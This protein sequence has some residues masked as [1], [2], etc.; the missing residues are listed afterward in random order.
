MLPTETEKNAIEKI[1]ATKQELEDR[2]VE[3]DRLEVLRPGVEVRASGKVD[4][5]WDASRLRCSELT[6]RQQDRLVEARGGVEYE[7]DELHATADRATL[8]VDQET[9]VLEHVDLRL[10]GE[11]GRLGGTRL[12]T[13]LGPGTQVVEIEQRDGVERA[14]GCVHIAR[15]GDVHDE[16]RA[17]LRNWAKLG[18][19]A[20][21]P[22]TGSLFAPPV[23]TS[24]LPAA[25]AAP[26]LQAI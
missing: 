14:D 20:A 19:P 11:A 2:R 4:V 22:Q 12:E 16:Q 13:L 26:P 8:N 7:S 5:Q 17:F 10:S 24:S 6:L 1:R 3:A 15:H 21:A 23:V 25:G 9:G 18:A